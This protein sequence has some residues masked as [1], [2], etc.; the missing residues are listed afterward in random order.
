MVVA[1]ESSSNVK[2][3]SKMWRYMDFS[4]FV[5]LI[6]SCSISFAR[7]DQFDD[8]LEGSLSE[9]TIEDMAK[10][11]SNLSDAGK[12]QV[13]GLRINFRE[14]KKNCFISCWHENEH[15]SAAMWKLYSTSKDV[16]AV[17]TDYESLRNEF[18]KST[19]QIALGS[20]NYVDYR[21]FSILFGNVFAPYFYK[22]SSFQHER[23]VRGVILPFIGDT[24]QSILGNQKTFALPVPI[25]CK[26]FVKAVYVS[27]YAPGWFEDVLKET[28]RRFGFNFDVKRSDLTSDGIW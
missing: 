20:V 18:N 9:R 5:S 13:Y 15:E 7:A 25:D 10:I 27:P 14:I 1:L 26:S 22:R 19:Y 24:S 23:E 3:N 28:C 6:S 4:K 12:W 11:S 21:T 16:V 2:L 8:L 17:Q